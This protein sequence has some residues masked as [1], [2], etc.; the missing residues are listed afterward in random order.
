[1]RREMNCTVTAFMC[2]TDDVVTVYYLN[3]IDY[4]TL[5]VGGLVFAGVIVFLSI[6]LLAGKSSAMCVDV[7]A[8]LGTNPFPE[9]TKLVIC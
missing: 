9:K 3:F 4:H 2:D 7:Q 5:R 8:S 1:M 6:L